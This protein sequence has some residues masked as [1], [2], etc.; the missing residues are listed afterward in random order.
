[1]TSASPRLRLAVL[2]LVTVSLFA[3]L[4]ARLWYLQVLA[5]PEFKV[6]AESNQVR[7][8]QEPAPRGRILDRKGR[9]LVG[10]RVSRVVTIE[11][12]LLDDD[13][14]DEVVAR[15]AALLQLPIAD[16]EER[17]A[18]QRYSPFRPVPVAEDVT[19]AVVVAIRE[20]PEMFPPDAVRATAMA[21]RSYPNG[22]LGAHLVGYVGE[23]NDRELKQRKKQGYRLGDE[24]GKSGVERV[25]ERFLR[26]KPGIHKLE[27]DSKGRVL[28]TLG[29]RPPQQGRDV[30]LTVD[31]DIQKAAERALAEGLIANRRRADRDTG[32]RYESPAG[33]VVV[34]D[35]KDGSVIAMASYPTY[36]PSQFVG[37]ISTKQYKALTAEGSYYPL[38]NWALQGQY[39]PGSTFKL[40]SASA[41]LATGL[42][43]ANTTKHDTGSLR[44]GDRTFRNAGGRSYGYLAVS[45]AITVSSDVFFYE[46]GRDLWEQRGRYGDAIQKWARNYGLG[47]VTGVPLPYEADGRIPT[48]E[49]RREMHDRY[50]KAFPEGNWYSGDNVN[51]AIGQGEVVVTPLQLANAY[52]TFANGGTRWK[53]RIGMKVVTQTG[54]LIRELEPK[55]DGKVNLPPAVRDPI[56]SGL[57]GVTASADGTAGY[58]FSGFPLSQYPVAGKTGTAQVYGKHDTALFASFAPA[59]DPRF[60]VAVVMEESG[61][62]S[63]AA[64]PIARRIYEVAFGL[65]GKPEV[66]PVTAVTG[67]GD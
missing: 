62:G 34:L 10:N 50:P 19:E 27:V 44:V 38:N 8:V 48:P 35:P 41:A 11:R 23:I 5:A 22:S 26:G 20:H 3:T 55:V 39:A 42:I 24:I 12:E 59:Y 36:D 40:V 60:C 49:T 7:F 33:S 63:T 45:R 6:A 14:R 28:G 32:Q 46:I 58:V 18:D 64:A 47:T 15:L 37:G 57:L 43:S 4:F 17:L 56:L 21:V 53:P 9:V 54:K 30:Q 29:Y 25:Y 65:K 67:V 2:G 1:M 16:I 31:L 13:D 51:L 52:A 61:F 66:P